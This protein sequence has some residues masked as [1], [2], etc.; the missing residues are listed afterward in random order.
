MEHNANACDDDDVSRM[1]KPSRALGMSRECS[2]VGIDRDPYSGQQD[3]AKAT[4]A[5][6]LRTA[7]LS[8]EQWIH[9]QR[10][11]RMPKL[12]LCLSRS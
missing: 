7:N 9:Y 12:G 5:N 1:Y 3:L 6:G 8:R 10:K 2:V 11:K 4:S